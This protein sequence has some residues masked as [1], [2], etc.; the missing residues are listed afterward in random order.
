M[1][2]QTKCNVVINVNLSDVAI[3]TDLN[4]RNKK[5]VDYGFMKMVWDRHDGYHFECEVVNL[6]KA[7][8]AIKN[9]MKINGYSNVVE[10]RTYKFSRVMVETFAVTVKPFRDEVARLKLPLAVTAYG[11]AKFSKENLIYTLKF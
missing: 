8:R 9:W 1:R 10:S 5:T 2:K 11:D 7:T 4:I 3:K 6:A